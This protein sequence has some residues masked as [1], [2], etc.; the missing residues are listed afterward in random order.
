MT[1]F[2]DPGIGLP[3]SVMALMMGVLPRV[4][5]LVVLVTGFRWALYFVH[6]ARW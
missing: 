3:A 6:R 4:L 2:G 1:F 5:L